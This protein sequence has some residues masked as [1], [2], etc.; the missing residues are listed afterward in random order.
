MPNEGAQHQA[1]GPTFE[2]WWEVFNPIGEPTAPCG[3]SMGEV[4]RGFETHG[5]DLRHILS[6]NE[7]APNTVWTLIEGDDNELYIVS[8]YHHVN[9][10]AYFITEAAWTSDME[11]PVGD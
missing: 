3:P 6:V 8:G 2:Q 4:A 11:I 9:R 10:L 7:S 5:A 1:A